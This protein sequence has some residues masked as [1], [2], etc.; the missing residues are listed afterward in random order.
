MVQ[1]N[2]GILYISNTSGILEYDGATW[3]MVQGTNFMSRFFLAKNS[4]ETI[5]VGCKNDMGYLAPDSTG[6][7]QFVSLLPHLKKKPEEFNV[8]QVATLG[9]EVY[10]STENRIF[11]WSGKGFKEWFSSAGFWGV[12]R[13][14]NHLYTIDKGQGVCVLQEEQWI[15]LPGTKELGSQYVMALLAL[16]PTPLAGQNL[17]LA[18]YAHG[19]YTYQDNTLKKLTVFPA[20]FLAEEHIRHALP[21]A[22]GTIALATLS[23]GV[24]VI[25][26]KGKVKKVIDK[27]SGLNDKKV[28]SLFQDREGG[29]WAGLNIGISRIDYPAPITVLNEEAGFDGMVYS[30][31]KKGDNLYVGTSSGLY[32]ADET[33]REAK[34]HKFPQLQTEVW[35]ILDLGKDLLVVGTTGVY[36]LEENTLRQISPDGNNGKCQN[37]HQS[38]R[39]PRVFYVGTSKGLYRLT[40]DKGK[41]TWEGK[42]QGVDHDVMWLAE[43]RNGTLWAS[44]SDNIS[45]VDASQEFGLQPPVQNHKQPDDL[46]K[47][48][49]RLEV[50]ALNGNIYLGTS[51]GVYSLQKTGKGLQLKPDKTFGHRFANGSREAINLTQSPSGQIWLTSEFRTGPLKKNQQNQYLWDTISLRKIPRVDVWT[52]HPAANGVVYLGTTKGIFR[53]DP[54]VPRNYRMPPLMVLRKIKLL[55]DSIVFNGAFSEKGKVTLQQP[56]HFKI[57]L[58]HAIRSIRFEFA[59][60]SLNTPE[61][62][63]YRYML[64]GYDN[65]WSTWSPERRKEYTGLDEGEYVFKVMARNVYGVE[66][67]VTTFGF[68]S[69]PPLYRTWWAYCLYFILWIGLIWSFAQIKHRNLIASKNRLEELVHERTEQLKAEKKKS[70]DLLLNILPAETAEEL[71]ANGR[72][73]A[74]SYDAV[75]VL[76]TDFKDFTKISQDLT[77]EELV[78]V[79]DFYFC[80]FDGI[81]SKYNIEKIKTMGDAYMCAGGMP[82]PDANTPAD[83]VKAGME[84]AAFVARLNPENRPKKHRLEIRI[85]IHTGPVVAGIVGTKKFAY[86]I[87]GDTVN[88]AARMETCGKEGKINISGATYELIKDEFICAYRGKIEAK[89]KGEIDMYF[90]EAV[91]EKPVLEPEPVQ[92]SNLDVVH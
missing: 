75:T 24:V 63:Q 27:R 85:G 69:M 71:K 14:G 66:S 73:Q 38:A 55:G 59:A 89:N 31:Q 60:T 19:L 6:K 29:L 80:A 43:D 36:V 84:I 92:D 17:L 40:H 30:I 15:A 68:N 77:P 54:S 46:A 16:H 49:T 23:K 10:F 82:N 65:K 25:D 74:Q 76:F 33:A 32:V 90:V 7:M 52:I 86:D 50:H 57:T 87:W 44:C 11:R 42:V 58:P 56:S 4:A 18:T 51:K 79:I 21:L 48:L 1:D 53:Y 83:V 64:E 41:W 28:L 22:D 35:K 91:A 13:A 8:S 88:T 72:T 5:F 12:F 81:I 61:Q 37:V 70:D 9:Q 78:T 2:R 62:L 39:N 26:Q 67:A 47:Q 34:F 45:L 3:Q 20:H